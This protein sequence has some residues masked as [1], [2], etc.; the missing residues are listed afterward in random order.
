MDDPRFSPALKS[1]ID[2][3]KPN[4]IVEV[5]SWKGQSAVAFLQFAKDNGLSPRILCIDTW[6]GSIEHWE[7]RYT[8]GEFSF[9]SLGVIDGQPSILQD[10]R[11]LIDAWGFSN[12]VE[13]LRCPSAYSGHFLSENWF[14]A[15]LVYIDASHKHYQKQSSQEMT[16]VG[17]QF[18]WL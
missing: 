10:F 13:I 18:V 1:L 11:R 7:N 9:E 17:K 5:G 14:M 3:S 4:T 8:N 6:L 15:D 12:Q 16:S 2:F